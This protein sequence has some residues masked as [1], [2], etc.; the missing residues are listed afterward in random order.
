MKLVVGEEIELLAKAAG[1]TVT[2][3]AEASGALGPP[4]EFWAA[5][6]SGIHY[7]FQ[8]RL[9]KQAMAVARKIKASGLP[10]RAYSFPTRCY[11]RFSRA[12]RSR[13]MRACKRA[14]RVCSPTP[15]RKDQRA[16]LGRSQVYC[17]D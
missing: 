6:A 12:Q 2:A 4:H 8:P 7:R 13:T 1:E 9:V 17:D 16:L 5:V 15:L 10:V 3:L 14:G 11:E